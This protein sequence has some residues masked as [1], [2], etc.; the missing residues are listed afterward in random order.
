[1]TAFIIILLAVTSTFTTLLPY[2]I[3]TNGVEITSITPATQRGKVG[4]T[5]RIIGTINK[6][7]GEYQIWFGNYNVT[8]TEPRATGNLVN[9]TFQVPH[10]PNENYTITLQDIDKNINATALF[11]VET[12]YYI[13]AVKIGRA[14]V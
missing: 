13:K 2:A 7:D 8:P 14:H 6:T 5:V 11:Y 1:M 10:V 9:A 3:A 12:A 4:D